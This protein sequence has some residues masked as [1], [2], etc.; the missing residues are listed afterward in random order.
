MLSSVS[1]IF[2]G[3]KSEGVPTGLGFKQTGRKKS[4][5][6]TCSPLP[7][8]SLFLSVCL[9]LPCISVVSLMAA[10]YVIFV[11]FPLHWQFLQWFKLG[12]IRRW[13]QLSVAIQRDTFALL[14]RWRTVNPW[15]PPV[16]FSFLLHLL[17]SHLDSLTVCSKLFLF[18]S[19][20]TAYGKDIFC[21]A[22]F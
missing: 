14:Q 6:L 8:L 7:L 20:V 22:S 21:N 1:S 17:P 11:C 13:S 5:L 2:H 10:C 19:W 18:S 9:T 16:F 3:K 4:S 12:C 15:H